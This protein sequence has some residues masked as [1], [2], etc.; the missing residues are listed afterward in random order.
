M[1]RNTSINGLPGFVISILFQNTS[2]IGEES[3]IEKSWWIKA[4]ATNSRIAT[5]GY[6]GIS[7]YSLPNLQNDSTLGI[8]DFTEREI[9]PWIELS[10]NPVFNFLIANFLFLGIKRCT[11]YMMS[12]VVNAPSHKTSWLSHISRTIRTRLVMQL[13]RP[14]WISTL[15]HP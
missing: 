5:S 10:C 11:N 13:C 14:Q 9:N 7:R 12:I 1:K 15:Y 2:I 6:I 3:P 8:F 4:L